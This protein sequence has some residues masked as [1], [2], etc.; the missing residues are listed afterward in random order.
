MAYSKSQ[1]F[2]SV[3]GNKRVV[4]I[5]VTADAASGAVDTGL[6]VVEAISVGCVSAAT[7]GFKVKINQNS[8]GTALNGSIFVSSAANGDVFHVICHGRG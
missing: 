7:A 6:G 1:L 8:A 5:A 3:Y 4:G 2:T